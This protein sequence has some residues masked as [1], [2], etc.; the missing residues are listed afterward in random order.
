[1]KF[2]FI[3]NVPEGVRELVRTEVQAW[4]DRADYPVF[5]VVLPNGVEVDF[6]R[7]PWPPAADELTTVG[8]ERDTDEILIEEYLRG[9]GG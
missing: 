3:E 5:G 9:L 8:A 4:V 7:R 1:M 6:C 2:E